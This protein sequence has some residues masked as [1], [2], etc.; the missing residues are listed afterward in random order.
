[1]RKKFGDFNFNKYVVGAT[2]VP[3]ECAILMQRELNNTIIKAYDDENMNSG[4]V[5]ASF[6]RTW[7]LMIYPCQKMNSYGAMF[8]I[9]PKFHS[10]TLDISEKMKS[11]LIWEITGLL[12]CVEE[13][14]M[15]TAKAL[16]F[17]TSDWYGWFL[18][19]LLK[20]CLLIIKLRTTYLNGVKYK[21]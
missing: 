2:Y 9:V 13:I 12:L 15:T 20:K 18:S 5:S 10:A 8:E 4:D 19:Y 16:E 7:P 3:L 14:W 6:K 11:S 1:M 21:R 17:Y